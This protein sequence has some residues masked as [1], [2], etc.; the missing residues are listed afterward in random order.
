MDHLTELKNQENS[1]Y[2]QR[3]IRKIIDE[4]EANV[5]DSAVFEWEIVECKEDRSANSSCICGKKHIR[6]LYTIRNKLN[7]N[8]LEPIGS[9]CIEK[10][11]RQD[12]DEK[13]DLMERLYKLREGLETG[14]CTTV[15]SKYF[16]RKILEYL[17]NHQVFTPSIY[18]NNDGVN[19]YQFLKNIFNS[20]IKKLSEKQENKMKALLYAVILPFLK[21]NLQDV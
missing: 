13:I 11:D 19:D 16:S 18:N 10:F 12:F 17:L 14:E 6:Y 4:S 20:R 21:N 2:V 1:V 5:W 15:K 3:F 7:G 8:E 9:K